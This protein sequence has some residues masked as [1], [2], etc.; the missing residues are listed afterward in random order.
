MQLA[1]KNANII[2][3]LATMMIAFVCIFSGWGVEHAYAST[4]IISQTK[5]GTG[6]SD[7][8]DVTGILKD[9]ITIIR[10]FGILV[11][12]VCIIVGAIIFGSSLGNSQK[13]AIGTA[14]MIGAIVAI[15][16]VAKAPNLADYIVSTSLK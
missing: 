14:A 6:S 7:L 9:W 2:M 16:V 5:I 4:D 1:K 8:S 15:I 10:V 11:L 3:F 12:V 13:R